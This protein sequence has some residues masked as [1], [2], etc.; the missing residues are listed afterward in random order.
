VV[1][2]HDAGLASSFTDNEYSEAGAEIVHEKSKVFQADMVLKTAPISIEEIEMLQRNQIVF[3]PIHIPTLKKE[4]IERLLEKQIIGLGL[5][6]I[7]DEAGYYPIVRSMS[8]IA[9]VHAIHEASKYLGNNDGGRGILLG[10]IAGVPPATVVIIGAGMVGEFAART[11]LGCG[12]QVKVFDNSIYRLMRL[13]RTVGQT[14]FTSVI[15]PIILGKALLEA[16]VVIGALKPQKGY[17]PMVVT[18]EMVQQMKS[19]S[20]IVDVSIDN[21]G[22]FE[23]SQITSHQEPVYTIHNVIHYCVPNIP[24]AVSRTASNAISNI[25]MPIVLA[26][27]EISGGAELMVQSKPGL[28]SATYVF[29][30]KLTS[31]VLAKK[32]D[33]KYTDLNLIISSQL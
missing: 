10:G 28:L 26:C 12:A 31:K 16:D 11:A 15:D 21:G 22:C 17:V 7:K 27:N 9:G 18:E 20:V 33:L 14:L 23:T 3:S 8:Q 13:Q 30:G 32:F 25:L 24:S 1:L 4:H 6:N 2:E 19:G 29:K 5:G